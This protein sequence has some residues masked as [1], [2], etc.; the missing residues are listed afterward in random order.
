MDNIEDVIAAGA[1]RVCVVRAI[2]KAGRI[3]RP[4]LIN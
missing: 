4:P 1:R 3:R 2:T